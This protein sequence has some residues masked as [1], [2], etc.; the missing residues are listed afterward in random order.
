MLASVL[1]S[2]RAIQMNILIVRAFMK[3]RYMLESN[4]EILNQLQELRKN[5]IEQENQILLILEYIDQLEKR[6]RQ[7]E[8]YETRKRIGFK[9]N[10]EDDRS[11][12][13]SKH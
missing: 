13:T 4:K 9:R 1:N 3:L 2:A 6:K 8:D 11:F 7:E 12:D 5:D 10:Y